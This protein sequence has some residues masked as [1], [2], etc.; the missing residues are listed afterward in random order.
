MSAAVAT[1]SLWR[2]GSELLPPADP[3]QF[4]VRVVGPPGQKVESTAE[5]V[6]VVETILAEAAGDDLRA[7]LAEVGRLPDDDRLIREQQTEENTAELKLRLAAGGS[8]AA[9]VVQRAVPAVSDLY[10]ADVA[11]EVG[12]TALARALGTA[13]PPV[14]VEIAGESIADLRRAAELVRA[15]LATSAASSGTCARRSK[16]RRRRCGSR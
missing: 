8:S 9:G 14:V 2:L 12:S 13:G 1:N 5:T 15:R 4:S 16:A 7:T 6:A 3:R 11:W 10:G